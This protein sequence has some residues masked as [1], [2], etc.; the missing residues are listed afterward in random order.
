MLRS[1]TCVGKP[2]EV[3]ESIR[4][5]D[6]ETPLC[7][8][9][10]LPDLV[11]IGSSIHSSRAKIVALK[12]RTPTS[13]VLSVTYQIDATTSL[14]RV[15]VS[16]IGYLYQYQQK[17]PPVVCVC[18]NCGAVSHLSREFLVHFAA[19]SPLSSGPADPFIVYACLLCNSY[20]VRETS[21]EKMIAIYSVDGVPLSAKRL[22]ANPLLLPEKLAD[23]GFYI[24]EVEIDASDA[25]AMQECVLISSNGVREVAVPSAAALG[26]SSDD[27]PNDAREEA[28]VQAITMQ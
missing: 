5:S 4:P 3:V 27:L 24:E 19:S 12:F 14:E 28:I 22:S 26:S 9:R 23:D 25:Q 16:V 6:R 20:N 11:A 2:H 7:I 21:F 1:C 15:L 13:E 17:N 8:H 10:N 18:A